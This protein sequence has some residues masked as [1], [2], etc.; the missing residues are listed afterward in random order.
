MLQPIIILLILISYNIA[1][2]AIRRIKLNNKKTNLS[3][4]WWNIGYN[5]YS[6]PHDNNITQFEYNLLNHNWNQ[7]DLVTF[8]EF[9]ENTLKKESLKHIYNI[10]PYNKVIK[11]GSED[12]QSYLVLS[13]YKFNI[14]EKE[15][16]WVDNN[17]SIEEK[18]KYKEESKKHYGLMR[19]GKRKIINVKLEKEG[20]KYNS[21]FYHLNNPWVIYQERYGKLKTLSKILFSNNHP[22]YYQMKAF[23]RFINKNKENLLMLGD[24]NCPHSI[25][26]ITPSCFKHM[27]N[28]APIK[29]DLMKKSTFPS[30][31]SKAITSYSLKIDHAHTEM[32]STIEVLDLKG[33]D[34]Y[35]IIL[36]IK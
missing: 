33:S 34:H 6:L 3:V 11:Y 31:E 36:K 4:L 29:I 20:K 18:Q 25:L 14:I 2:N 12:H 16:D 26:G 7:Y 1:Q 28:I 15:L 8:G 23:K 32:E 13:K 9:Q 5:R 10:F 24:A 19:S 35:P 17:W 22:L 21:I 27:N 30:K